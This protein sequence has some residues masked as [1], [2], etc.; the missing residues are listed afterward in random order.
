MGKRKLK[1]QKKKATK[2]E[3]KINKI[4]DGT[5]HID[6]IH[7][8]TERD[9]TYKRTEETERK[10]VVNTKA[11]PTERTKSAKKETKRSFKRLLNCVQ[12]NHRKFSKT[13]HV[14]EGILSSKKLTFARGDKVNFFMKEDDSLRQG[15]ILNLQNGIA[16]IQIIQNP[17]SKAKYQLIVQTPTTSI[18]RRATQ[19][20]REKDFEINLLR[21]CPTELGEEGKELYSLPIL[22]PMI[23]SDRSFRKLEI[24]RQTEVMRGGK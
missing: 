20:N 9:N 17:E 14:G 18:I 5:K 2:T 7:K 23:L 10:S 22:N 3:N 16:L 21:Q 1:R 19:M 13:Q 12:D 6:K 15:K 8:R 24:K 11:T 4:Q